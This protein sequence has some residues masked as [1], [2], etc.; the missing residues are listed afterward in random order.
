MAHLGTGVDP[1]KVDLFEGESLLV[2]NEGFTEG[3]RALLG[4]NAATTDHDVV[5]VN[6]T[7]TDETTLKMSN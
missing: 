3:N 4:S 1:F 5:L 7:V 2:L 6:K